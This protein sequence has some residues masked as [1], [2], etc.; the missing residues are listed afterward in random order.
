MFEEK[1]D[2][3]GAQNSISKL[4]SKYREFSNSADLSDAVKH[5]SLKGS[6]FRERLVIGGHFNIVSTQPVSV[7]FSPQLGYKFNTRFFIGIGMNYR[8]TFGDSIRNSYFVS[9]AN[10]S[11]K[12]FISH[13]VIR[14][15]YACGEWEKSG[16]S[17]S[18]NDRT[19]KQWKD[20]YF[21]G[22][23]KRFLV[24]SKLYF[25]MTALYNLNSEHQNPVHPNRFQIRMGFQLSEGALAK[26]KSY[27]HPNRQ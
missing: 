11:Y 15:F 10:T 3:A 12:A 22:V 25:T 7:D 1:A 18:S 5:T 21:V 2:I 4:M 17:L 6:A 8:A 9:P 13:D 14:D 23:G 26:R 16:I 20:N 27:F 24:H 19:S